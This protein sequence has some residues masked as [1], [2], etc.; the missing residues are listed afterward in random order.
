MADRSHPAPWQEALGNERLLVS[1]FG[2]WGG[3]IYDLTG[4]SAIALDDIP[5]SGIGVGN[6]A[7][8]RVLRAPGEQTACCELFAYD[9]RGIR[10]YQRLD[11]IRDPHD[12]CWHDGA[13]HITSSWDSTVWRLDPDGVLRATWQGTGMPDSWHVN[14][15]TVVDGRLH[16][17]AFGRFDRYKAWRSDAGRT[18]GFVLDTTTG[19]DVLAG[20]AHPHNPVWDGERWYVCE[21]TR[22]T[23]T[24]CASDGRILRRARL[25]RFT[26][27]MT[28]VGDFAFVGGNAH[29]QHD[30]DRADVAVIDLDSFDVVDRI[31]MPCLEIYDIRTVPAVLARSVAMGFGANAA[32]AVEQQRAQHRGD[33]KRAAN[34]A[35]RI[36]MVTPRVAR[37]LTAA[38]ETLSTED[39][40]NCLV[41]G[42]LPDQVT[43]G[44]VLALEVTIENHSSVPL[45]TVPPNAIRVGARWS[46]DGTLVRNP[47]TALPEMIHPGE[48]GVTEVLLEV[49]EVPGRYEVRIALHQ[50]GTGW[51]GMRIQRLVTVVASSAGGYTGPTGDLTYDDHTDHSE[52][53]T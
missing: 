48:A 9:D 42:S 23:L 43:A 29:R 8:W 32:R 15:L 50:I 37:R 24:E 28:V 51:F 16:V 53:I 31:P 18:S 30:D 14:S 6:G 38:G 1:G 22:G 27:G 52:Y 13:V 47:L 46:A 41:A 5:T 7:F 39:A 19:R 35:A 2:K 12:V 40:L 26:R 25:R 3:G 49:P 44:D 20:L 45:A 33:H 36:Q 4:G 11:P 21:S 17:S 10:T 34:D